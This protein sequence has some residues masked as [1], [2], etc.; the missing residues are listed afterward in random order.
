M[1]KIDLPDL[2]SE[3]QKIESLQGLVEFLN[4]DNKAYQERVKELEEKVKFCEDSEH[5][6]EVLRIIKLSNE[7]LSNENERLV[8]LN[9][10]LNNEY[11]KYKKKY[12][13]LKRVVETVAW[14]PPPKKKKWF[15]Q[16]EK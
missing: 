5:R 1:D 14:V 4:K 16:R 12:D 7:R 3:S 6:Q 2:R 13:D 8:K 10:K 11:E 15:W 9:D